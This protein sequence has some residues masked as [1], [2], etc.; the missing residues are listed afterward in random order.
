MITNEANITNNER[1]YREFNELVKTYVPGYD[2]TSI[3]IKKTSRGNYKLIDAEG[4][5]RHLVSK[6]LLNDELIATYNLK[7]IE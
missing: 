2:A 7:T 4:R 6:F 1:S 3:S 5:C